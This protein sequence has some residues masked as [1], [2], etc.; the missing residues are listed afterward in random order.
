MNEHECFAFQNSCLS[1]MGALNYTILSKMG[2]L[3]YTSENHKGFSHV[4]QELGREKDSLR[5]D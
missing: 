1:K 5:M 3:N 2:A 4:F